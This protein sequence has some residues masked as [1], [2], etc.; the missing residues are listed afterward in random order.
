MSTETSPCCWLYGWHAVLGIARHQPHRL[1]RV[2]LVKRR[3]ISRHE[4]LIGLL[5]ALKITHEWVEAD[6][7]DALVDGVHQGVAAWCDQG[8]EG[9]EAELFHHLASRGTAPFLLLLD[10]IQDPR[11]LGA[12]LRVADA[13]GCDAVII[14]R[15]NTAP[16]SAVAQKAAS[17]AAVR[18]YRVTNLVRVLRKLKDLNIWVYGADAA[19]DSLLFATKILG[20]VAW[21]VGSEGKGLR[22]LV[23]EHCDYRVRIPMA[24]A[25]ESLNAATATA[26]CLFESYRQRHHQ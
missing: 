20:A 24:E 17:G 12:C 18:L 6:A 25:A 23:A 8:R 10:R 15:H 21:V 5:K 9:T 16:L 11:N 14:E 13:A 2:L 22:R 1:R 4:Q 19:G 7:L 3:K 26:V